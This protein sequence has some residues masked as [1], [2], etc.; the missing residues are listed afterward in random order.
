MWLIDTGFI[1]YIPC[2][3]LIVPKTA[4]TNSTGQ[5]PFL[6]ENSYWASYYLLIALWPIPSIDPYGHGFETCVGS[7]PCS[8]STGETLANDSHCYLLPQKKKDQT[9][10]RVIIVSHNRI[11]VTVTRNSSPFMELEVFLLPCSLDP[12][13]GPYPE[14]NESSLHLTTKFL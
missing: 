13:T 11:G 9:R 8:S 10:M 1:L 4:L 14:P 2:N 6:E 3:N 7:W 12:T 5:I